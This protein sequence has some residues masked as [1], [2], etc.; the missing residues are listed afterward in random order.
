[1]KQ[2][3]N[4]VLIVSDQHRAN[5]MS[6]AGSRAVHT[7][8]LGALAVGGVRFTN[9]Y[10]NAPVCVPSRM[11]M[12]TGRYPHRLGG[13]Y[14]NAHSLPS[15]IPT[16]A[17]ALSL[18]GYETE[19]CGRM[20]FSGADQRHGYQHRLV[21]D[22]YPSYP[23][24]PTTDWGELTP[25]QGMRSIESAGPGDSAGIRYDD[26]VV[27]ACETYVDDRS[28]DPAASPLLLTVGLFGPHSPFTCP[29][30]R[31]G[32]ADAAYE[33]AD[34][35]LPPDP[36]PRHPWMAD[37]F[38]RLEADRITPAQLR[39]ARVNYAGLVNR[40]DALIGRVVDAVR[41]LPGETVVIY[42]SDHGEMAG[43]R[44][45]FWK[46]SF[47]EGAV[48]VPMIWR[49][50]S[51]NADDAD[52]AIATG[53]AV[54]APV[55]LVDLAPTLVG[56]S[57]GQTM[58]NLDGLDLAPLLNGDVEPGTLD[59][60]HER[61]VFSEAMVAG[62]PCRMIRQ[63]RHKLIYYHDHP[64]PQLFDLEVDPHEQHDLGQSEAH[65]ALRNALLERVLAGWEPDR[66]KQHAVEKA[67]DLKYLARW[68]EEVGMGPMEIWERSAKRRIAGSIKGGT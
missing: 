3:D 20:H 52:S 23:G 67:M 47:F 4:I 53:H 8:N 36:E 28:R 58:S 38:R 14:V 65:E 56:L 7:P 46:L 6:C 60:W 13:I 9:V 57:S 48:K 31:Y 45:M 62:S 61:P 42:L 66:L 59:R 40:L 33:A 68:G 11:S 54:D 63:G 34:P 19:L 39:M 15:D 24:G 35:P 49:S 32:Q 21:G 12:L 37:W 30:E 22:I 29:P 2:P 16:V 41:S 64:P 51:H 1:M 50:F 10:C 17:H 26:A 18:A 5:W 27:Q 25:A 44:G 43:D 55:S